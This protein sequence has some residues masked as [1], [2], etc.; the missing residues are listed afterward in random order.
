MVT[1]LS[2]YLFILYMEVLGRIIEEK[3]ARKVW[4]PVKVSNSGPAFSHLFFVDDLLFAKANTM[5]C[6]SVREAIEEFC[7]RS[8]QK[9]NF[10]K[11]KVF[12][13]M[14][15]TSGQR[16]ELCDILGFHLTSNLGTYLGFPL[17]H[18]RSSNQDLNFVVSRV[19]QKLVGW[20]ANLLSFASWNVLIQASLNS[21]PSYVMQST[22]LPTRIIDKLDRTSKNFLWGSND[23]KRKIHWV[24]WKKVI[25]P[26]TEG[27]LGIQSA[28]GRNMAYLAKLNW[29][30]H[31][32]KESFWAQVLSKKY[33]TQRRLGSN[34]AKTLPSTRTWKAMTKGLNIFKKS[35]RWSLGRDSNILFG[36]ITGSPRVPF[37]A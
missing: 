27:G 28:K 26:K 33:L 7:S 34:N 5:N 37:E 11:S 25:R 20:K 4:N 16:E 13:S 19:E 2:P 31:E 23:T 24:G 8:G 22:L 17:R 15:I 1:P 3:C 12:F 6:S 14:N 18:V 35:T 29:R 9:I 36:V 10:T 32:E 30:F 21:I